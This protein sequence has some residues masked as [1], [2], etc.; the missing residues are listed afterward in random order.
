MRFL[1]RP[2][3]VAIA[4]MAA[5]VSLP[6][7]AGSY[8]RLED[9]VVKGAAGVAGTKDDAVASETFPLW[10]T[11]QTPPSA[12]ELLP[13]E[14]ARFSVVKKREPEVDGFS[15]L[16]GLAAVFH[17]DALY[18]FWGHN[19]GKENTPTEIAQGRCSG[20]GG[21]TWGPVWL[22]APHT[23]T[24][25]RSHGVFLS[26]AGTLWAFLGRF[27]KGYGDL[28]MEAFVLKEE[29][30]ASPAW[31][32]K[33]TAAEGFWPCDE[34]TR[35]ADGN[36][37]MAGMDI[38]RGGKW[39]PPAVVMSHGD[40]FTKWDRVMLPVPEGLETIW[41]ES[42]V[43][44]EPDELVVIVRAA[45]KHDNALVS[46]SKDFGR[47]WTPLKWTN[48]PMPCTKAYAGRLSTGQ[49]YVVGTLVR[50]HHR[51]RHPLTIAVSNPGEKT[52][53][54]MYRIRDDV[55][56]EGPGESVEN[57]ALSYPYAVEHEGYLYV[58]YSNDGGRGHNLNSGEMAVIPIASLAGGE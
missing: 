47:T 53:C 28:K 40:D 20:D 29:D 3:R 46:T 48:L 25:G 24:E 31:E 13:I 23:E 15:W 32:L 42:T 55:F 2:W 21:H 35:M 45:W 27:G 34:P 57:A 17:N 5:A 12:A 43:I 50:D 18:T 16:H 9:L 49:R 52:L 56:P 7:A 8:H 22:I 37:V 1:R 36:W 41:G 58:L 19:K 30:E 6:C 10:D 39:A 54:R 44:V 4:V 11:A 14:G 26:H 33:G 38:P 51:R